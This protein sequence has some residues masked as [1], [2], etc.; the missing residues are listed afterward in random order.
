MGERAA[1]SESNAHLPNTLKSSKVERAM[2]AH[3][4]KRVLSML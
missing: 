1:S 2:V 4:I 3:L